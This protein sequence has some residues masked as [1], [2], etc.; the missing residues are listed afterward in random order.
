[1]GTAVL[2]EK[3]KKSK[4]Q[5]NGLKITNFLKLNLNF[6]CSRQI[7]FEILLQPNGFRT[8]FPPRTCTMGTA[9]LGEIFLYCYYSYR[10]LSYLTRPTPLLGCWN[11]FSQ[12]IGLKAKFPLRTCNMGTAVLGEK[13]K[14]IKIAAKRLE[15]YKI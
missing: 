5:P 13:T 9:V 11:I 14:K 6:T 12:P 1:M 15:I 2:G 10:T 3:T 7:F 8:E 4:L